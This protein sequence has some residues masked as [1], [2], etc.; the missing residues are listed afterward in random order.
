MLQLILRDPGR[1][2]NVNKKIGCLATIMKLKWSN[3]SHIKSKD[4][5]LYSPK[6]FFNEC[7]KAARENVGNSIIIA[8]AK[9]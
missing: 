4:K 1:S 5:M 6:V 7:I 9:F 3:W 2:V 8:Y